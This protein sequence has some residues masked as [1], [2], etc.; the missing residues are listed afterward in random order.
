MITIIGNLKG[1]TGKSTISF[2]LAIWLLTNK[3]KKVDVFDLDPQKTLS[4]VG[5][6]RT[7]E[8]YLPVLKIKTEVKNIKKSTADE[9]LVDIGVSDMSSLE[10]AISKADRVIIPVQPSQADVW[11]TQR[12]LKI[13]KKHQKPKLEILCFIN[14]ADT[15]I[16][17]R[18]TAETREALNTLKGITQIQPMI[19]QRTAFRRSFSEGLAVFEMNPNSKAHKEIEHLAKVLFTK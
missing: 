3:R 12:F 13:I 5:D 2:N 16:G 14:R 18:E 9:V 8:S 1:G 4:D 10:K 19:H 17:V 6:V 15:H 7:E 11:S